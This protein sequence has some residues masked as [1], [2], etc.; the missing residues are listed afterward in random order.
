MR[1]TDKL[2]QLLAEAVRNPGEPLKNAER[3]VRREVEQVAR[4]HNTTPLVVARELWATFKE[5]G[6]R[7][8]INRWLSNGVIGPL[9]PTE[10]E[11]RR[12]ILARYQKGARRVLRKRKES[13][14]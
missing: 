1:E 13:R 6:A 9:S 14:K 4:K 8:T 3:D 12:E 7:M 10:F 11:R 5:R 2:I